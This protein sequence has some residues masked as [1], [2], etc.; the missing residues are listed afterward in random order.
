MLKEL[1]FQRMTDFTGRN[2]FFQCSGV[3]IMSISDNKVM[4]SPFT[5]KGK[6]G[7]CDIAIPIEDI[8]EFTNKLL[9]IYNNE[10]KHV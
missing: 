9:E 7:R 2:G 4:I 5:S 1:K 10:N 6:V 3:E 8:P